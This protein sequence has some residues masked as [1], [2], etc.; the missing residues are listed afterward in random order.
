MCVY[1]RRRGITRVLSFGR[2][3]VYQSYR[4]CPISDEQMVESMRIA[5]KKTQLMPAKAAV[6]A[7]NGGDQCES[8]LFL[9]DPMSVSL[10]LQHKRQKPDEA[11]NRS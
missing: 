6:V 5:K 7:E 3:Q 10:Q 2:D 11:A 9:V 8:C 4:T 1:T